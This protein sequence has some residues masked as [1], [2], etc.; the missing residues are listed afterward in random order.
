MNMQTLQEQAFSCLLL[1]DS[2]KR[3][4]TMKGLISNASIP[5]NEYSEDADFIREITHFNPDDRGYA[6]RGLGSHRFARKL[7]DGYQDYNQELYESLRTRKMKNTE[8]L[9]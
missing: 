3:S 1:K 6:S 8:T 7:I 2:R 9:S 5:Y 4:Q